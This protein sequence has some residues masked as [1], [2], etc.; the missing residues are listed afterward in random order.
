VNALRGR[1][2]NAL[3]GVVFKGNVSEQGGRILIEHEA[4]MGSVDISDNLLEGQSDAIEISMSRGNVR[5]G[6]NY[7]EGNTGIDINLPRAV[8]ISHTSVILEHQFCISPLNVKIERG[9]SVDLRWQALSSNL[10]LLGTERTSSSFLGNAGYSHP[11]FSTEHLNVSD[12]SGSLTFSPSFYGGFEG[13]MN[14]DSVEIDQDHP[15]GGSHRVPI[16]YVDGRTLMC[17]QMA[18][19]AP[20]LAYISGPVPSDMIAVACIRVF[21]RNSGTVLL[22]VGLYSGGTPVRTT[23]VLFRKGWT[24]VMVALNGE[25]SEGGYN[26]LIASIPQ[27]ERDAGF[28]IAQSSV[29]LMPKYRADST[30]NHIV[31]RD[32]SDEVGS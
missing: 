14:R 11:G 3:G 19:S 26:Y 21:R 31:W 29:Y 6:A 1:G 9:W 22:P 7:W 15:F 25:R 23:S 27:A 30:P 20:N 13:N 8:A 10:N 4:V 12:L 17:G 16:R 32:F 5:I 2:R 18:I 24:T 28:Y